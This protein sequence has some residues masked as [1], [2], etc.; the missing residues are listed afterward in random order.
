MTD[1]E[2]LRVKEVLAAEYASL[3][4]L[5]STTW[6]ASLTRTTI[7]LFTLSSAGIALG[8]AAQGG[9]EDG[10]FWGLALVVLPL[11]LFLG[12]TTFVRIVQLQRESY[13]Y[14]TGMNRIRRFMQDSAP[15]SAPYFVLPRHDDSVAIF[16][17]PGTGMGRRPPRFQLLS[18]IAQTQG[19]VGVV[20]SGIAAA[21][22]GLAAAPLGSLAAAGVVAPLAF[23]VV[24]G[25]LMAYW[26][27]SLADIR[28]ST[29]PMYPTPP[30]EIDAPY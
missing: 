1:E 3:T 28:G 25:L 9:I 17:G 23:I 29:R 14:L 20:T 26:Q 13:V 30:E 2:H 4:A 6:S 24:L 27:R 10:P 22:A 18:L 19:V 8:F 21:F 12:V 5:L 7:F 11:V 15:G 16:R